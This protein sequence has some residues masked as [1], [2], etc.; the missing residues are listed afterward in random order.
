M[1][2][3]LLHLVLVFITSRLTHHIDVLKTWRLHHILT[4]HT[5]PVLVLP[6]TVTLLVLSV[7]LCTLFPFL[8][9]PQ[10]GHGE[11]LHPGAQ[12]EGNSERG[13]PGKHVR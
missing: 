10:E 9:E 4:M 1:R 12:A 5:I 2:T 7:L 3:E 11:Q 8:Q 6:G 13:H